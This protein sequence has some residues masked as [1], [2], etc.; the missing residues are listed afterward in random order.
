MEDNQ[1]NTAAESSPAGDQLETP[2]QEI[3]NVAELQRQRDEY[4][5]RLL[6][7]TAEFDNYR[8][9]IERERQAQAE[10]AAAERRGRSSL[11]GGSSL[12]RNDQGRIY[13]IR[14]WN[15]DDGGGGERKGHRL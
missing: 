11:R 1:T 10:S 15:R 2:G 13:G 12:R 6:R 8:K 4:Y 5:D 9:R 3:D 7:K 14:R